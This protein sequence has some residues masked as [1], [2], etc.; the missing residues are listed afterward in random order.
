MR[1]IFIG[2]AIIGSTVYLHSCVNALDNPV[3]NNVQWAF[4]A[5]YAEVS[6]TAYY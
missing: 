3:Y 2:S 6:I 1:V 4:F 5:A